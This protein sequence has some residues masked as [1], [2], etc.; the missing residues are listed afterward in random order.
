MVPENEYQKTQEDN[1]YGINTM[2]DRRCIPIREVSSFQR[3]FF[4][5]VGT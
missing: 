5:G 4:N 2:L 3:V 1:Q